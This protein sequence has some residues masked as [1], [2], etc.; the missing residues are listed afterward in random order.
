MLKIGITGGIGSGK[1]IVC[2]I[3]SLFGIPVYNADAA[4]KQLMNS[5]RQLITG[6]KKLFGEKI[7]DSKKILN[8]KLFAD[9]IFN[10]RD[11]LHKANLLIHPSVR[12]DFKNW[13]H[14]FSSCPY[15]IMEA[16][17]LF[18]SGSHKNLDCIITVT[19]PEKLR[20]NR[21][22]QRD[23]VNETYVKSIA[24]KQWSENVK[25]KNSDFVIINDEKHLVIPQ[26]VKLHQHF[27][28]LKN[29]K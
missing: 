29:K 8:K 7:Y 6:L 5:D 25:K 12:K 4:A 10:S 11:N 2:K 26:V 28:S 19:A 17:I 21:V 23:K 3:F 15:I 18:E 20:I 1:S 9:V 27:I 13:L 14:E 16:A 24:K 22:I